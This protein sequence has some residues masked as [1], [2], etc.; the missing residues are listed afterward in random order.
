VAGYGQGTFVYAAYSFFRQLPAG[1]PGA[2]R[3]FANLLGLAEARILERME[4]ARRVA[5]FS[6]MNDEQLHEVVRLMSERWYDDGSFLAR[7]GEPGNELFL[8]LEGEVEIL[9][10]DDATRKTYVAGE[11]EAVGE[12]AAL[13]DAP[14]S[15]SLRA[16]NGL[17]V[18][19]IRGDHFRGLLREH[20]DLTDGVIRMLA[21]R[22][23]SRE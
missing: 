18:L 3:L 10:G 20:W 8:V 23:A 11:G 21:D 17:K 13:T 2:I 15:A 22:L 19:S 9:K 4:R 12:L 1:V 14:R 16:R 7:Q 5:L 6:F